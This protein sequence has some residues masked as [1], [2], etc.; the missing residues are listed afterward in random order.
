[1]TKKAL[2]VLLVGVNLL[3]GTTLVLLSG[4]PKTALAQAAPLAANY[5]MVSGVIQKDHDALYVIDLGNRELHVFEVD[6]TTRRVTHRDR[7]DLLRDFR[8]GR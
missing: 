8:G 6:R 3:L 5:L 2:I 1:M 4:R 7:R